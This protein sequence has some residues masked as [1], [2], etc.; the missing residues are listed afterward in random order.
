MVL[1]GRILPT[2]LNAVKARS[3]FSVWSIRLSL[4]ADYRRCSRT[5]RYHRSEPSRYDERGYSQLPSC[6]C[7]TEAVPLLRAGVEHFGGTP[8]AQCP[9]KIDGS[10]QTSVYQSC[11][12]ALVVAHRW[13][14]K[15]CALQRRF[16]ASWRCCSIAGSMVAHGTF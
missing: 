13:T 10:R 6:V 9:N 5:R 7:G 3:L 12:T 4:F 15:S 1:P 14:S 8:K 2:S 16:P 11:G